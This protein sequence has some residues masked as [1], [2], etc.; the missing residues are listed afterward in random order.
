MIVA[1]D[2]NGIQTYLYDLNPE[3]S[4]KASKLLRARSFQIQ[5]INELTAQ[6]VVKE[7][8]LSR[9]NIF[10]NLGVSG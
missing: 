6:R 3:I 2:L 8:S 10:S 4:N 9:L 5:M 7:L 1:G